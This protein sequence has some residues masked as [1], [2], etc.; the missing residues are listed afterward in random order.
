MGEQVIDLEGLAHHKGSAFGALGEL[1]Q[2]TT[3]QFENKLCQALSRIDPERLLWIED[4][5][6]NVGRCVIP[7]QFYQQDEGE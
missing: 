5:S 7:G 3:E 4:E 2:P 1:V 6:R